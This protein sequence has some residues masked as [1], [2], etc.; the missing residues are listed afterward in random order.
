[1]I[2][3]ARVVLAVISTPSPAA[4]AL[5]RIQLG[6]RARARECVSMSMLASS[7]I[8]APPAPVSGTLTG[9]TARPP[10]T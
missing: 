10:G 1:V 3:S 9:A 2:D 7:E 4:A 8:P 5:P 6:R